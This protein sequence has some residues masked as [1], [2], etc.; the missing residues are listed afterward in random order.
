[1]RPIAVFNAGP[2][3][4]AKDGLYAHCGGDNPHLFR[5][6]LGLPR[7]AVVEVDVQR[8]EV[9]PAAANF[10]GVIISGSPAMVTDRLPW[11]E[12]TADWI[13]ANTGKLPILGVCFGHQ[14]L[15]H[16]L[17]GTV[18]NNPAG[19]EYGT[20]DVEQRGEATAD[21][22]FAGAPRRFTAQAAHS[23]TVAELPTGAV[24]LARNSHG[25]QAARYGELTWGLQFHPEF[26]VAIEEILLT[27]YRDYLLGLKLDPD[28]LFR[29]LK[30]T[31][32][33]TEI[34]RRFAAL[35]ARSEAD[36]ARA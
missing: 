13:A 5:M 23:Q 35:V 22:V 17:G 9:L 28:R 3:R 29:E 10:S 30:E 7:E 11:A 15:A 6:K 31:P 20:V 4:D 32:D 12:R 36:L 14:L 26:D 2:F 18:V 8:L 1:M 21:P 25:L 24:E 19:S 33:A 16:A 34:L 27:D